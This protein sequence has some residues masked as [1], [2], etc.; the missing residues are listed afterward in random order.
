MFHGEGIVRTT[1][2]NGG[3]SHSGKKIPWPE[4][5]VRVRVPPEAQKK[6]GYAGLFHFLFLT[7]WLLAI[8]VIPTS[9]FMERVGAFWADFDS[10]LPIFERLGAPCPF[11]RLASDR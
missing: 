5:A 2:S 6:T 1:N 7:R 10:N 11:S 8:G 3:E 9:R 4:T